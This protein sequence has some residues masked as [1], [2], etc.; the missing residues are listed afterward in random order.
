MLRSVKQ[1]LGVKSKAKEGG[2]P[3]SKS[4]GVGAD[5]QSLG[6]TSDKKSK[7][8]DKS[9]QRQ[10]NP[11]AYLKVRFRPRCVC[12]CVC[13]WRC[14]TPHPLLPRTTF[15]LS[16]YGTNKNDTQRRRIYICESMHGTD[17]I[18]LR[19]YLP[20]R[21]HTSL[22]CVCFV[23]L[24]TPPVFVCV[25]VCA[26]VHSWLAPCSRDANVGHDGKRVCRDVADV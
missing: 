20:P 15:A 6:G 25:C 8:S 18:H 19:I 26:H 11:P 3:G 5:G 14:V 24:P 10:K 21:K 4:P 13:T 22:P 23:P 12:V 2:A 1:K 7:S 17:T 16:V 9:G